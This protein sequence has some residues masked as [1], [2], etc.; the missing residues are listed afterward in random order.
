[1]PSDEPATLG[2]VFAR[3]GYVFL[4]LFRQGI[5]LSV[6]QGTADGDLMARALAADGARGRNNVQLELLEGEELHEAML[7]LEFLRALPEVDEHRVALAG[8]SFGGALTL[9]LASRDTAIRAVVVFGAAAA[10]W[11]QSPELRARLLSAVD[12]SAAPVLFIHATN[13]YSI[14]P[15]EALASEMRRLG[16]PS[17]L[18]VYPAVGR[19]ARDGH[20]LV[21]RSVRTW[22]RDVFTFLTVHVAGSGSADPRSSDPAVYR[23]V[24]DSL[25]VPDARH[26]PTQLVVID[27]TFTVRAQD[28]EVEKLPEVDKATISDFQE[29]NN[30]SHSVRYLSSVDL[31]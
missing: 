19:D 5:G 29:R 13:D 1:M 18:I 20:N 7:G 27:S 3:H 28:F 10:S 22:E 2:P 16:K 14:A 12:R 11:K 9:L 15:G 23:A 31:S 17:R 4:F 26:R 25:S 30:E 8:H 21:Y 24:L 6:G